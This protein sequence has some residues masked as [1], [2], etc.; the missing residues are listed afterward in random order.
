MMFLRFLGF[1][2]RSISSVSYCGNSLSFDK[3]L[4]PTFASLRA[5][6]TKSEGLEV[7]SFQENHC[8]GGDRVTIGRTFELEFN[9]II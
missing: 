9:L 4:A 2:M 7:A 3:S 1:L 5:S 8:F 6:T